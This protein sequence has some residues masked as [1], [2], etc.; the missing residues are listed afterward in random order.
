M[1]I[2]YSCILEISTEANSQREAE[3]MLKNQ[4]LKLR[5]L[6]EAFDFTH[7]TSIGTRTS[8]NPLYRYIYIFRIKL[9]FVSE[10]GSTL[11][12]ANIINAF[13]HLNSFEIRKEESYFFEDESEAN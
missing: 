4:L 7:E 9:D 10:C 3:K 6:T 12:K 8:D 11:Q 1:K 13:A 5:S 2:S